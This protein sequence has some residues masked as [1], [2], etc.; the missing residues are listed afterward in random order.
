MRVEI[1]RGS[2]PLPGIDTGDGG[3]YFTKDLVSNKILFIS[4]LVYGEYLKITTIP[5]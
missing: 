3:S 5:Y 1:I 2:I 4:A